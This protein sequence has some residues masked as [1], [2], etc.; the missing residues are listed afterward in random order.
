MKIPDYAKLNYSGGVNSTALAIYL[1]KQGWRGPLVNA[2]TGSE[3][4]ET[5]QYVVYF[6]QWLDQFGLKI[7]QLRG[8]PWQTGRTGHMSVIEY[9]ETNLL[10]PTKATRWCTPAWKIKPI[11]TWG[12]QN[13]YPNTIIALDAGERRRMQHGIIYPL[14]EA[15]I[16]RDECIKII[17]QEGL[18]VPIKS[19]CWICPFSTLN[20][21]YH[22]WKKH[23]DLFDRAAKLEE[24][25]SKKLGYRT[26]LCRAQMTLAERRNIWEQE[27]LT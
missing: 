13:G 21:W 14:I 1:I 2:W 3:W 22:L 23:P 16:D 11:Q 6:Q 17:Y 5:D 7:I 19:S 8:E 12:Q 10:I 26:T 24:N 25:I 18:E 20:R 4:P 27:C 15:G 9:C